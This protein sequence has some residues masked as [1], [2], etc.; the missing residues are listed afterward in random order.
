[1]PAARDKAA[2]VDPSSEQPDPEAQSLPPRIEMKGI[3][4]RYGANTALA[5]VVFDVRPGEIHALLGENGAGKS[6]LMHILSGLTREDAGQI[7]LEGKNVRVDSPNTAR[8]LGIAMVHQHFTLVPA[9]TVAE[10]L[11]LDASRSNASLPLSERFKSKLRYSAL[12]AAG[13]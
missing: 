3:V 8:T 6:T 12:D 9:F 7:R 5:G 13:G 2:K 4:K 11:A 10:N 1:M